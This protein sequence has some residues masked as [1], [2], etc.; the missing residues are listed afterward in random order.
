MYQP[1]HPSQPRRGVILLVVIILLTLFAIVGLAFVYYA[2]SQADAARIY[3]ES[4]IRNVPQ[5]ADIPPD[6]LLA[7]FLRQLI[8]DLKDILPNTPASTQ[9][10]PA[11]PVGVASALRGHSLARTM[12]GYNDDPAHPNNRAYNGVGRL[13][14]NGLSASYGT[15]G[16][17]FPNSNDDYFGINYMYFPIDGF[18]RDPEHLSS[19]PDA[20]NPGARGLYTGGANAPYT[21]ADLNS[22]FLAAVRPTDSAVLL[23]S[24]HRPWLFGNYDT[25][26]NA[27][28]T[29]STGKYLTLRPRPA[30]NDP[31]FPYPADF[32]G[33][34]KNLTGS[35]GTVVSVDPI[36]KV[37]TIATNDSSWIDIGWPVTT[38]PDGRKFKPL[39]APL[40]VD[41]NN[42]LNLNVHGNVRASGTPA[43]HASNQGWGPWEVSVQRILS[44]DSG[45]GW[46]EWTNL[47]LGNPAALTMFGRY[48]RDKQPGRAGAVPLGGSIAHFYGQADFDGCNEQG[49]YGVSGQI[50]LPTGASC[51]PVYTSGYGNG[52]DNGAAPAPPFSERKN[53]PLNFDLFQPSAASAD[54]HAFDV[55]N[56]RALL[57][58]LSTS[59]EVSACELGRLCP[60]NFGVPPFSPNTKI[61]Q[62]VTTISFD[63]DKAGLTPWLYDSTLAPYAVTAGNMPTGGQMPYRDITT[64]SG[65]SSQGE[66]DGDWRSFNSID[67][68]GVSAVLSKV[69]LN[70]FLPPY[71]HMGQG[72]TAVTYNPT[73]MLKANGQPMTSYDRFDPGDGSQ[74]SQDII[75][76]FMAAQA[77]R[78]QLAKDIY[79]RLVAVTGAPMPAV[80][81]SPTATEMNTV[82][83]T[84]RWLAQ[85]SVNIVDY[86]DDD[87]ISTPFHFYT[88]APE[89]APTNPPSPPTFWV[90]G[91]ELPRVVL[92]EALGEVIKPATL[93][94]SSA[95]KLWVELYNPFPIQAALPSNPQQSVQQPDQTAS[96]PLYVPSLTGASASQPVNAAKQNPFGPYSVVVAK[97]MRSTAINDNTTGEPDWLTL[98]TQM[99][100][101]DNTLT[102]YDTSFTTVI[103]VDSTSTPPPPPLATPAQIKPYVPTGTGD[104]F[105]I[106]GPPGNT[107]MNTISTTGAPSPVPG[108]TLWLQAPTMQYP[109]TYDSTG[110][111]RT[112]DDV[113]TGTNVL[114][115]RLCNPH[116]PYES[117]STILSGGQPVD[118][119]WY[120]PVSTVDVL[121]GSNGVTFS[122]ITNVATNTDQSQG[123]LQPYAADPTV[124]LTAQV[125]V[126]A[127]GAGQTGHTFGRVNNP[128]PPSGN[129]DWLV[130]LDRQLISPIELFMVSG[131]QPWQLTR[132]FVIGDKVFPT[133]AVGFRHQH[134]VHYTPGGTAGWYQENQ[135]LYRFLE[136]VET[137]DRM[138]GV[139]AG[140][141]NPGQINLNTVWDPANSPDTLRALCALP[142]SG[143]GPNHFTDTDIV[144]AWNNVLTLRNPGNPAGV[145]G[146]LPVPAGY[147]GDK[148][149]PF[150]SLAGPYSAGSSGSPPDRQFPSGFGLGNTLLR[151]APSP[152]VTDQRL[153]QP[154]T[155][156]LH[157]YFQNEMLT[158]I[159]NNLT[160]RSNTFA[161]WLTV[162]F[163]EVKD[164]T[165]TP[166]KLGAEIG[167][168]TGQNIRHHMFAIV[169]RSA[170]TLATSG[171]PAAT[172]VGGVPAPGNWPVVMSTVPSDPNTSPDQSTL[173]GNQP[174]GAGVPIQPGSIVTLDTG[175]NQE[176]VVVQGVDVANKTFTARFN[177]QHAPGVGVWV[178]RFGN[179]GPQWPWL[180]QDNSA[181]VPYYAVID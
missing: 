168:S 84:L 118:N 146:G 50:T 157:P 95:Y 18:C 6:S 126:P 37:E 77:A 46:K 99:Q 124:P 132:Q 123:K 36:T 83:V 169:D 4:Q 108:A 87:D 67:T 150:W 10:T 3:R 41:L 74:A 139:V 66:Y 75:I 81:A 127:P 129:Y 5:N 28:W 88:A 44:A 159:F 153:F 107:A 180:P 22:L 65:N 35:P 12:Y 13:H 152:T 109:M 14:T 133:P 116:I 178:P 23:P 176:T 160:T 62:Q 148:D 166:P 58:D 173:W 86:I 11:D 48:G 161:V 9:G 49:G 16:V 171:T 104:G 26:A 103:S 93:P 131:Y 63:V 79:T 151:P 149:V 76:Q 164:D 113:A 136:F 175:T 134:L 80:P 45:T 42:R 38:L 177:K 158:K 71:P 56:M 174:N 91:T 142:I 111:V 31:A 154:G 52:F 140:G 68:T 69:D 163:F 2:S 70:R 40:I 122:E 39:F 64:R 170:L 15:T 82:M 34:V 32:G 53:H 20:S 89:P 57:R 144:T 137:R 8:Y 33:D 94:G 96:V 117:Y 60:N 110:L 85:L 54:D 51:F 120:N 145:T 167:A 112:P 17:A 156:A 106:A 97:Q 47:F 100:M 24:Y 29:D 55:S 121:S 101:Y 72:L 135:R 1:N 7:E 155:A 130:H 61:R 90:V 165:T 25:G 114:L 21:A 102:S 128:L 105:L 181:V 27:H 19:R 92:N 78:Q 98:R 59:V 172:A 162:G 30:D 43:G 119:P 147:P 115:R 73:P 179:P 143:P 138:A 141:R 125:T